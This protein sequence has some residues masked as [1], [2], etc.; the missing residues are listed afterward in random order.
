M[1]TGTALTS[2][3]SMTYSDNQVGTLNVASSPLTF[4]ATSPAPI[5]GKIVIALPFIFFSFADTSKANTI[6]QRDGG[7][8][9][10]E[11][12]TDKNA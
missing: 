7:Y 2:S 10:T 5:G 11:T 4:T 1:G 8:R 6:G 12:H 3:L 9:Q